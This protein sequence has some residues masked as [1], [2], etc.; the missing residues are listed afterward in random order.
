M[1]STSRIHRFFRDVT[2][3]SLVDPYQRFGE[4]C[5]LLLQ[6]SELHHVPENYNGHSYSHEKLKSASGQNFQ[7]LRC[8]FNRILGTNDLQGNGSRY[9]L[10]TWRWSF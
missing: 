8:S 7:E 3:F 4:T 10:M 5:C 9:W 2:A 6:R 1:F